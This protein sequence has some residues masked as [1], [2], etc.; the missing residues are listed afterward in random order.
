[1]MLII[2]STLVGAAFGLRFQLW[3]LALVIGLSVALIV[4]AGIANEDGAWSIM[5]F[6]ALIASMFQIGYLGGSVARLAVASAH[7]TRA[8]LG[9]SVLT[10]PVK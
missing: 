2:V 3:P 8:G 9:R 4:A 7:R 5:T 1:M 6:S 10:G